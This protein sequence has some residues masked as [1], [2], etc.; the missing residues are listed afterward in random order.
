ME[1][2]K[3]SKYTYSPQHRAIKIKPSGDIP[4]TVN[5]FSAVTTRAFHINSPIC[6]QRTPLYKLEKGSLK[7]RAHTAHIPWIVVPLDPG[8]Q[9][10]NLNNSPL[11]C[12]GFEKQCFSSQKNTCL[13]DKET[14]RGAKHIKQNV[15]D[16][17]LL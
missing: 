6:S 14:I 2:K 3:K 9:V 15:S 7:H 5:S 17:L 4:T 12:F 10:E 8:T 13:P 1:C 11:G 16:Q